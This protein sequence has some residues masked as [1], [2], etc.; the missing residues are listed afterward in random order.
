MAIE[1]NITQVFNN[2]LFENCKNLVPR[3]G[4]G[5]R[6]F[7]EFKEGDVI[8]Q[9][10]D[11]SNF[12][13]LVVSGEVKIKCRNINK[14][15]IKSSNDFFGNLEITSDTVR[16]SS[17]VAMNDCVLYRMDKNSFKKLFSAVPQIKSTVLKYEKEDLKD[18]HESRPKPELP[19]TLDLNKAPIKFNIFK[20]SKEEEKDREKKETP[21]PEIGTIKVKSKESEIQ[22]EPPDLDTIIEEAKSETAESE[23]LKK[24][25]LGDSEDS[26]NWNFLTVEEPVKEAANK[27]EKPEEIFKPEPTKTIAEEKKEKAVDEKLLEEKFLERHHQELNELRVS[28]TQKYDSLY[29]TLIKVLPGSNNQETCEK[30]ASAFLKHFMANYVYIFLI[31]EKTSE[32][33]LFFPKSSEQVIAKYDEGLTGKAAASKRIQIIK[34][35]EKDQRFNPAFDKPKEFSKGTI[36]YIPLNDSENKLVGVMQLVKT[37]KDFT[38]DQEEAL[39]ILAEHAGTVLRLSIINEESTKHQKLSAFGST[40]NF[41]MQ[42]IKSPILTIKHYTNLIA[43]L[44]IP[45]QI[46]RVLIMLS[47]HANS[48]LDIMQATFDFS[49]KRSS[50]K[51]E[52]VRFNEI[53]DNILELL[54]EYT[55]SQNVKLFKK[56]SDN[57][58]VYID[59]RRMYVVCFQ[60]IKNSCEAM[61]KG[62]KIYVNTELEN[63]QIKLMIKDNGVGISK[64][65]KNDVFKAFFSAGKENASGLGLAIAKYIIELMKGT[66]T[67]ESRKNKG[68]TVIITLPLVE[69]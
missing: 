8:F 4:L 22:P 36:A 44:D 30:I 19:P 69:E 64:E 54:S 1:R 52:K 10:G 7:T 48:V 50:V 58:T 12:V 60:I 51:L 53:I 38:P 55:E 27:V 2:K 68:T 34:N 46:K 26:L 40:S 28:L 62:G 11:N 45:E 66:I 16:T 33:E 63:K 41:L 32:L 29:Q 21:A 6:Y 39:K 20:R 18:E 49:E 65:I 3:F 59:P 35:P 23:S 61:P 56:F 25:L 9:V 5:N 42:D 15:L 43:R 47:M 37:V 13:Y 67:L 57:V 24:E 31:S 14:V 17:A